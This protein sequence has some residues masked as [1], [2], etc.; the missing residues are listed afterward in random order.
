MGSSRWPRST[1]TASWTERG[2]PRSLSASRAA[3]TVRPEKSTSSTRT[4]VLPSTPSG[5]TSVRG[6]ALEL[7][8][9]GGQAAGQVDAASGD[10]EEHDPLPAVRALQDLVRDTAQRA[11]DLFRSEHRLPALL[12]RARINRAVEIAGAVVTR[13]VSW[14]RSH[15]AHQS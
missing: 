2:R 7:A 9:P 8:D 3:R 5:G 4:T 14:F 13:L 1:R 6:R 12:L 15:S 10:A 11:A